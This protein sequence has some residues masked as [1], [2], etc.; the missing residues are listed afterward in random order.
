[1]AL[2]PIL[3]TPLVR[4]LAGFLLA[5]AFPEEVDHTPSMKNGRQIT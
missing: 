4:Q 1:M 5:I 3:E 2:A